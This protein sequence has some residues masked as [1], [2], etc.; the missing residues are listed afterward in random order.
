MS[1]VETDESKAVPTA[2]ATPMMRLAITTGRESST[3]REFFMGKGRVNMMVAASMTPPMWEW[4][5]FRFGK[6]AFTDFFI[7]TKE[8][9]E[10]RGGVWWRHGIT[11][12][13]GRRGRVF[14]VHGG[15]V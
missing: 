10:A 15:G 4:F 14:L 9:R 11:Q 6:T 13:F 1:R 2:R 7:S 5:G 12:I 8:W 3:G